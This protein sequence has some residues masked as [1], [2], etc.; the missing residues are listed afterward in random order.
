MPGRPQE[1][2]R[3]G[4]RRRHTRGVPGVQR[5][6]GRFGRRLLQGGCREGRGPGAG[7]QD[8]GRAGL[9]FLG[10][11]PLLGRRARGRQVVS[12]ERGR[13]RGLPQAGG[14]R[15]PGFPRGEV[16]LPQELDVFCREGGRFG[17]IRIFRSRG[18]VP[19]GGLRGRGRLRRRD[20]GGLPPA[21]SGQGIG[22]GLD[23]GLRIRDSEG[24]AREGV[25]I[26]SGERPRPGHGDVRG[27]LREDGRAGGRG[28]VHR[29]RHS[30]RED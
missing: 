3:L 11:V 28:G 15:P 4:H 24:V 13:R 10:A 22:Q 19:R 7:G 20:G 30:R 23:I 27:R 6:D 9:P 8:P 5:R 18:P 1:G 14:L 21:S 2:R 17:P 26:R 25:R 29:R 12:S 16:L